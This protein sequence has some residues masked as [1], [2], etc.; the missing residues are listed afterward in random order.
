MTPGPYTAETPAT[1]QATVTNIG[2]TPQAGVSLTFSVTGA[3]VRSATAVTDANGQAS[4]TY[5]GTTP[6]NDVI[7]ATASSGGMTVRSSPLGVQWVTASGGSAGSPPTVVVSANTSVTL[8]NPLA[9]SATVTDPAAPLGG[10]IGVLWSE[11]SGPAPMTFADPTQAATSAVFTQ[12]G[13]YLLQVV[14]T[15]LF[16]STTVQLTPAIT[17]NQQPAVTQGWIASPADGST[18][19]GVVP[20]TLATGVTLSSGTLTYSPASDTSQVNVLTTYALD[21]TLLPNGGYWIQLIGYDSN[22]D[23]Q[24]NLTFVNVVGNYKPGRVTATVTD[25]VVPAKGLAIQIQRSYDSLNAGQS[26]DFGYGWSLSMNV[27]LQVNPKNNVT[28]TLGGQRRTFYFAPQTVFPSF[29]AELPLYLPAFTAEPGLPGTL[30]PSG[31]GCT[32]GGYYFWDVIVQYGNLY[33]CDTGGQYSP[34]GYIYTDQFG[35]QYTMGSDGT[36][37]SIV[38]RGGNTLTVTAAGITSSTGLSVPFVRDSTGAY[39]ADH[40]HQGEPVC[41]RLRRERQP[42]HGDLPAAGRERC[43]AADKLHVLHFARAS[44]P[45]RHGRAR[46]PAA[47]RRL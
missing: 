5:T 38:D 9:L 31:H 20:I 14:A 19:T 30:A 29:I 17:V 6:G 35:T 16:G 36:L 13:T 22:G 47:H 21:T 41:I 26:S 32:L 1:F 12:P 28:F 15:D 46:Q 37:Q 43:V 23:R 11:I 25:L 8:P 39:H 10:P 3:N 7:E 24:N 42:G 44:L 27:G 2:G 4:F 34:P 33:M 40:G 18:V 45:E